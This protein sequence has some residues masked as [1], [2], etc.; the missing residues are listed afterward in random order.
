MLTA[1]HA[2]NALAQ[3]ATATVNCRIFPGV[4]PDDIMSVL[5]SVVGESV[6]IE[7]LD[8]PQASPASALRD[9]VT[10]AVTKAVHTQYPKVPIFPAMVPWGTDGKILRA[11]GIPT[12]GVSGAFLRD[13][14]AFAHG[15][16][17]RMPVKSFYSELEHWFIIL[18]E[19]A[20][21]H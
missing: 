10:Q 11:N 12:Y 8:K 9:D 3:S 19:L 15:L 5:Q 1:G 7:M 20:G 14:D 17:E 6:E 18:H 2:E 21:A 4:E 13:E 16:N